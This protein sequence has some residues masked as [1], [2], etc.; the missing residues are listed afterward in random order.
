M[1]H[2]FLGG[3]FERH[4]GLP[5]DVGPLSALLEIVSNHIGATNGGTEDIGRLGGADD[6]AGLIDVAVR[7]P[8][9]AG[10]FGFI[11]FPADEFVDDL[12]VISPSELKVLT[13]L[14]AY[15]LAEFLSR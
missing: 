10:P 4:D 2:E 8:S 7:A 9:P 13:F 6:H 15:N 1:E 5:E 12:L 3:A 14:V 11:A